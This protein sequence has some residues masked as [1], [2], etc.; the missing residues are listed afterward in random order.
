V[1]PGWIKTAWGEN[2]SD[3]WQQRAV[4]EAPLKRWGEPNDVASAV[5]FLISDRAAFLTGQTLN[6]NGGAVSS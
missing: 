6:V 5:A 2:A 1:A 4:R 3:A